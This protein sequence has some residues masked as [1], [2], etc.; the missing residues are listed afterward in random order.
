MAAL[1]RDGDGLLV[2]PLDAEREPRCR[3]LDVPVRGLRVV[4]PGGGGHER[5]GVLRLDVHGGRLGI[6]LACRN[7][8]ISVNYNVNSGL[9]SLVIG[10]YG[11]QSQRLQS[12]TIILNNAYMLQ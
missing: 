4:G 2:L 7:G 11:V 5:L 6:V 1:T 10:Y 8:N 12:P 3:G 9:N